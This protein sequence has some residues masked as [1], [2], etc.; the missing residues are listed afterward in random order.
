MFGRFGGKKAN[1]SVD[2]KKYYELLGV[3]TNAS[4]D[5][6]KKAYRK[7]AVKL[8]PDKGGD[9]EKFKEVTR[10]F[11]VLSDD[12]KRRVYDEYGEEGLSQQ[13]LGASMNAEDI[14]EAFFGGGL[15]G[16][17]KGKSRG[18]KKAE[19]VVHTLKVTLK[20]LYLGK[21]AKL[22]L[23]RHRI[24]SDCSGKGAR[25]GAEAVTCSI[26]SG[27]GV[28]VQ[29]RQMGPGM[30][31]QIQTTCSECS[32]TGEIIRDSDKCSK[33]HGKKV[34]NEKKILEVYVEPGMESG[35]KI[36]ISGEADEAPGC[37]PGDVIIVI[38]EKPHEV[39]RRRGIHLLLKKDI[40]LVEALCGMT[41]VVDHLDGRRLLLK[42]EPG[43]IIQPDML[44]SIIG[45]GMPV[46]GN[47][48][49][50]GNLIIQFHIVFPK[51]LS[52]EQQAILERTLGPRNDISMESENFEQV[53]MVDFDSEQLKGTA[54]SS[55]GNIYDEDQDS[56]ERASRVQ[57]AQ[58]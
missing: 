28:R 34:I 41:A 26:C 43:E 45:E 4:K 25:S 17:S 31:Q 39:F 21:T 38:E 18:P 37:L 6:I 11:E 42:T 55:G 52:S 47:P 5:E 3:P 58:Q 36:I 13:G 49:Q 12:E 27:R 15:F 33:C 54:N 10:A 48:I 1:E 20:D 46:K 19:D 9:E 24:C 14:F 8:H 29:I 2:N 35:Q 30:I 40:H 57:C 51:F 32:G 22:A 56:S 7:L 53:Q 16:R 50:K 44:K 23:N